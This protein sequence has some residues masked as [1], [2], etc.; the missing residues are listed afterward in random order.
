[1]KTRPATLLKAAAGVCLL[2]SIARA[3][4]GAILIGQGCAGIP[5]CIAQDNITTLVGVGLLAVSL[6]GMAGD[7]RPENGTR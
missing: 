5:K 6:L 1:M 3:A 7:L 4:G 2:L